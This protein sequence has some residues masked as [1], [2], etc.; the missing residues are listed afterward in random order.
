MG[1]HRTNFALVRCLRAICALT[2]LII[3]IILFSSFFFTKVLVRV[4]GQK[5][6]LLSSFFVTLSEFFILLDDSFF[7]Q[8]RTLDSRPTCPVSASDTLTCRTLHVSCMVA[9]L[10]SA[11]VYRRSYFLQFVPEKV[12]RHRAPSCGTLFFALLC[13]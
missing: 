4:P 13:R 8:S 1:G 6:K 3:H 7:A 9:P 12:E 2:R 10:S 11:V 5:K